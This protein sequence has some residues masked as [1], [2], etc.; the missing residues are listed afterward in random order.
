MVHMYIVKNTTTFLISTFTVNKVQLHVSAINVGHLIVI[1]QH[2]GDDAPQDSL[3]T[4]AD[5][6]TSQKLTFPPESPC[7]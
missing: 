2:N 7:I 1:R 5:T 3:L 6:I 4:M